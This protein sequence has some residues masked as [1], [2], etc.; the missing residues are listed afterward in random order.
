MWMSLELV[1]AEHEGEAVWGLAHLC[2]VFAPIF[3]F[4]WHFLWHGCCSLGE[5]SLYMNRRV[6]TGCGEYFSA[7]VWVTWPVSHCNEYAIMKPFYTVRRA[8]SQH[9]NHAMRAHWMECKI[10]CSGPHGLQISA[11]VSGRFGSR[12]YHSTIIKTQIEW[13]YF[14]RMVILPVQLQRLLEN[15]PRCIKAVLVAHGV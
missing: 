14:E 4:I 13:K 15:M 1:S 8:L 2:H 10:I 3:I 9:D 7:M 6:T 12:V 11:P 5:I